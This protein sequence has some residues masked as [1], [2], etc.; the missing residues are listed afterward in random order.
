MVIWLLCLAPFFVIALPSRKLTRGMITIAVRGIAWLAKVITGI[1]YILRPSSFVLRPSSIIAAKHMSW[2]EIIAIYLTVPNCFFI[3]KRELTWI[4]ILGWSFLRAG[5]IPVNRASG[6]TNMANLAAVVKRRIDA[7]GTLVIF[8]EG[9]RTRPGH[10]IKL[11]RGLLFIA[12]T[13][14]LP[15]QPVATDAGLYW[16]KHGPMKPGIANVWFENLL[17]YDASIDD[18]YRAINKNS[19]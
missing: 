10:P 7:G 9:T 13:L 1:R 15:I 12:E 4:P 19:P 2:L 18:V 17:P 11:K 5:F 8:P 6:A 3:L 16:P 14:K